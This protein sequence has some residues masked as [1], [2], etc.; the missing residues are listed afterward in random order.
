MAYSLSDHNIS[1]HTK[2]VCWESPSFCHDDSVG[3]FR[4][5][6]HEVPGGAAARKVSPVPKD[7]R[8]HQLPRL[9]ESAI[10]CRGL[11]VTAAIGLT[12]LHINTVSAGIRPVDGVLNPPT[13][14]TCT[15]VKEHP[16]Q[17]VICHE[18]ESPAMRQPLHFR[19][20]RSVR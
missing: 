10:P 20:R 11:F 12:S 14:H 4:A 17:Q 2:A 16:R 1:S 18:P 15:G 19:G 3:R 8:M 7:V 6:A 9:S 5:S 13:E